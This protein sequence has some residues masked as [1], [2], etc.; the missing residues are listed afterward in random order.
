VLSS[1]KIPLIEFHSVPL[2]D[3]IAN[4]AAQAGIN[5]ICDAK[6]TAYSTGADGKRIPPTVTLRW[7]NVTA[8]EALEKLVREHA[9]AMTENPTTSVTRIAN[10]NAAVHQVDGKLFGSDTNVLPSVRMMDAPLAVAITEV[11]KRGHIDVRIDPKISDVVFTPGHSVVQ[12]STVSIGWKNI[13]AKQALIAL[14]ENYD[15][16]VA[17]DSASGAAMISRREP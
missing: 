3:A 7:E 8:R 5:Y 6:L 15:L 11:A 17:K 14:C 12:P 16:I 9:L 2:T 10:T 1:Y 4:L 13:S